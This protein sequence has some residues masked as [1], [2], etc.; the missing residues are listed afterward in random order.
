MHIEFLVEEPSAEAAG[1]ANSSHTNTHASQLVRKSF[2]VMGILRGLRN[3]RLGSLLCARW[4]WGFKL[5][6]WPFFVG[7]ADR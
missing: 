3:R 5:Q 1:V 6:E 4:A 7:F 2:L